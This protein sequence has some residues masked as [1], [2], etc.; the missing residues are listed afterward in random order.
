MKILLV[1]KLVSLNERLTF[2]NKLQSI[3]KKILSKDDYNISKVFPYGDHS[4]N[5]E[6]NISIL[7]ALIEYIISTKR[8]DS[9]LFRN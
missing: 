4:F 9:P 5:D 3:D 7:T 8:F 6:K 2:F 1:L